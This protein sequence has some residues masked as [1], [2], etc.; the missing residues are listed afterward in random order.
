MV[1]RRRRP[2]DMPTFKVEYRRRLRTNPA[3]HT[4]AWRHR[5]DEAHEAAKAERR[6]QAAARWRVETP[7]DDENPS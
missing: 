1:E 4:E 5:A 2:G 3:A 7:T 6:R